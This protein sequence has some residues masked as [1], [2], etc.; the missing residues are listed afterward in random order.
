MILFK[1][2]GADLS[3]T[4]TPLWHPCFRSSYLVRSEVNVRTTGRKPWDGKHAGSDYTW[5]MHE[6]P[7][8]CSHFGQD[9]MHMYAEE[10][11]FTFHAY[12]A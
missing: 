7:S 8:C 5:S 6:G 2:G 11:S 4:C 1:R 9:K 3:I 12:T 10:P